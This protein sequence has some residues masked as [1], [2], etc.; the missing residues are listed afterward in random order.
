MKRSYTLSPFPDMVNDWV[1]D[2]ERKRALA[3]MDRKRRKPERKTVKARLIQVEKAIRESYDPDITRWE[4][5]TE[6]LRNTVLG[7]GCFV[8]FALLMCVLQ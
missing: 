3:A 4:F 8:V 2:N 5:Y 1:A 7:M 6:L